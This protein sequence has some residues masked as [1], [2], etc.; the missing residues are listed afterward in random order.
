[1]KI[2]SLAYEGIFI[3]LRKCLHCPMKV[4]SFFLVV[5]TFQ[6]PCWFTD[7]DH[8]YELTSTCNSDIKE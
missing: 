7:S 8:I 5:T 2:P 4:P 3:G 1:M 6:Q